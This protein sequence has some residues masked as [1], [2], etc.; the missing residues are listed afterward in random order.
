MNWKDVLLIL[1]GSSFGIG[2]G[3]F[4][5][6]LEDLIDFGDYFLVV[7]GFSLAI[8][9]GVLSENR[10]LPFASVLSAFVTFQVIICYYWEEDYEI[11][12]FWL[13]PLLAVVYGV[14]WV[15]LRSAKSGKNGKKSVCPRCKHKI[16]KKWVSC[17]H[18]G[19]KIKDDTQVYDTPDDTQMY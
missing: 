10:Y 9:C 7:G 3:I 6:V 8:L 1:F 15:F 19:M 4:S 12:P 11:E 13:L 5:W 18:C 17:P 2:Y 14:P 16:D